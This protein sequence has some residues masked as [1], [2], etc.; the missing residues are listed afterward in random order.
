MHQISIVILL[1]KTDIFCFC[2]EIY[3]V[4]IQRDQ[5]LSCRG[6]KIVLDS[7]ATLAEPGPSADRKSNYGSRR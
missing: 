6:A 2:V 7:Y 4:A 1:N 5:R 3:D